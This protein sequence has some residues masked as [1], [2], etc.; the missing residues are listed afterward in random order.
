MKALM[1][2]QLNDNQFVHL[3]RALAHLPSLTMLDFRNNRL[4]DLDPTVIKK[5]G[6]VQKLMLRF[7]RIA[8]IPREIK[9]MK[10]LKFLSIRNNSLIR[11]P[12]ELNELTNLNV[13]DAR[14]N[15][16]KA[17]PP[18]GN[19]L[20]LTELD[21]QHNALSHIPDEVGQ[22]TRL[23]RL[24]LGYN[25]LQFPMAVCTLTALVELDL[26]HNCLSFVSP[27]IKN[28][29][30]LKVLYLSRNKLTN[31]PAELQ[32]LSKLE[33]LLLADNEFAE[34]PAPVAKLEEHHC[35][36]ELDMR[37][38]PLEFVKN[39]DTSQ[40]ARIL[41]S[42]SWVPELRMDETYN[43][44]KGDYMQSLDR[45]S[46]AASTPAPRKSSLSYLMDMFS[47]GW[48][49]SA[50]RPEPE[51]EADASPP[52]G[53]GS[54][55]SDLQALAAGLSEDNVSAEVQ[56]QRVCDPSKPTVKEF[57]CKTEL[58]EKGLV[59]GKKDV[60]QNED[61]HV[62]VVPYTGTSDRA[63]FCVFDGHAGLNAATAAI[64]I[65]PESLAEQLKEVAKQKS[66]AASSSSSSTLVV[67]DISDELHY[68]F[69][70]ADQRMSEFKYEGCTATVVM[71]WKNAEGYRFV[72]AANVGDSTAYLM[73]GDEPV[74]LTED[75]KLA[76]KYER[77]RLQASGIFTN[78][79]Q[80]HLGGLGVTRALGDHCPKD[81]GAGTIGA[82]YI[83]DCIELTLSDTHIVIASDG[84]WDVVT[85]EEALQVCSELESAE[86]IAKKLV[87]MAVKNVKCTDNVTVTAIV[88]G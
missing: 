17:L 4:V 41:K 18:L 80:T 29:V 62:E 13:F 50:A 44:N 73:R 51:R 24:S 8:A 27:D 63:L 12:I 39:N 28:L 34:I 69:I 82:P 25:N 14:N 23:N 70:E 47:W 7:N 21:L 66:K 42:F 45:R 33:R 26:E 2:L 72:Q 67:D 19:L 54:G 58:N 11:V 61:K 60:V 16:L 56:S 81:E 71:V 22:M 79:H 31:L 86:K 85:P 40:W 38:N 74:C 6:S 65:V 3:P 46:R 20:S 68:A 48:G 77:E 59:R 52:S 1:F 37:K 76:N 87:S 49:G 83:S 5:W 84:L 88:L 9:Y 64:E 32:Q 35:L 53:G 36:V 15:Q 78:E 43:P 55:L 30:N 57:Y 75:H 10:S